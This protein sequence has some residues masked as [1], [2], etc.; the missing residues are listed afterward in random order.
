MGKIWVRVHLLLLSSLI[1]IGI[2]A[3]CFKLSLNF[4]PSLPLGIYRAEKMDTTNLKGK[5]VSF[6]PPDTPLFRSAHD[7]GILK[8]GR[9]PSGVAPLLKRVVAIHGDSIQFKDHLIVNGTAIDH[10][11]AIKEIAVLFGPMRLSGTPSVGELWFM[12]DTD[13]SFDSR[14]FGAI[15]VA[16]LIVT[17]QQLF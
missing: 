17:Q 6:C 7:I 11:A 1:I 4:T 16:S 12:G 8:W 10:S 3:Y 5:V 15:D 14:Y 2:A 9:C 13:D